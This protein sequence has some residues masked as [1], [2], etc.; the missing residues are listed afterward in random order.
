[1][2]I[3]DLFLSLRFYVKSTS[4]IFTHWEALNFDFYDFLHFLKAE[5]YHMNKS[6]ALKMAKM[7]VLQILNSPKLVSRKTWVTEKSWNFH[8]VYKM[9][10]RRC[11]I[12]GQSTLFDGESRLRI[13]MI[14][15]LDF[16]CYLKKLPLYFIQ[17]FGK[18]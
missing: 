9:Y 10:N 14:F 1:M 4:A 8:T 13:V 5:I 12:V 6:R 15:S 11:H 18:K 16:G 2:E 7:A 17:Q 3:T